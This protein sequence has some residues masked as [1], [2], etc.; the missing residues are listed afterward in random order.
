MITTLNFQEL[1]SPKDDELS[2]LDVILFQLVGQP[3][4]FLR[5]SYGGELTIHFGI[6]KETRSPKLKRRVRGSYV[7][8]TRCSA[9]FVSGIDMAMLSNPAA[10]G[11]KRSESELKK[12]DLSA[13]ESVSVSMIQPGMKVVSASTFP[14]ESGG[15]SVVLGFSDQTR[16]MV[17]PE[18]AHLEPTQ[19]DDGEELPDL[20]DWELFTPGRHLKVGPG[21]LWSYQRS[22]TVES[23]GK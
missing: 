5:P 7:L 22:D 2:E 13:I 1:H 16:I 10:F 20:A 9:W 4:L 21:Q 19:K 17:K 6:P 3:F 23:S 18:P 8:T 12:I 15:V 11:I 14:D